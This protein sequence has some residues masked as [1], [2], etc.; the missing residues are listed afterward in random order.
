M[1]DCSRFIGL[2]VSGQLLVGFWGW[3][4]YVWSGG[5]IRLCEE[6]F[7]GLSVVQGLRFRP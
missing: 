6:G 3:G 1:E 4:A 7:E 5:R 2:G